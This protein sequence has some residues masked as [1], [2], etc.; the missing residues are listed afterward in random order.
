[1][2]KRALPKTRDAMREA[3]VSVVRGDYTRMYKH[4]IS[5]SKKASQGLKVVMKAGAIQRAFILDLIDK[6]VQLDSIEI[7]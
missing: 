6:K 4:L 5:E 1:M 3:R 2:S 7:E